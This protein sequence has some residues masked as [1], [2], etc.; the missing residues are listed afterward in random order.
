MNTTR[1]I[2][3]LLL[4]A[5]LAGC[6]QPKAPAPMA[7]ALNDQPRGAMPDETGE[8][9]DDARIE[10]ACRRIEAQL[11][12]SLPVDFE[13]VKLVNAL[14]YIRNTTGVSFLINWAALEATG[15]EQDVLITLKLPQNVC[16]KSRFGR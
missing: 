10:L 7:Q 12:K 9:D 8:L 2:M 1:H 11:E 3:F 15:V 4:A 14:D 13:Q 16:E 6:Q 5:L